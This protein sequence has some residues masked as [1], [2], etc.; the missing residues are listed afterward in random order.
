M[1]RASLWSIGSVM[2]LWAGTAHADLNNLLNGDYT[3]TG[4][5]ACIGTF[6]PLGFNPNLTPVDGRFGESFSTQGVRTFNGD[7]TG[8]FNGISVAVTQPDT[9]V[10]LGGASRASK[11]QEHRQQERGQQRPGGWLHAL[12]SLSFLPSQSIVFCWR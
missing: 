2:L 9:P 1:R 8:T 12:A 11:Q 10:V 4:D 6:S 7:G 3:F 5:A